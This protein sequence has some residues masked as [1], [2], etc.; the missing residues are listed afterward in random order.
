[1][2]QNTTT[3]PVLATHDLGKRFGA[4]WA[5]RGIQLTLQSGSITG[6]LGPNGAGK[7]TLIRLC[8]GLLRPDAG[9]VSVAGVAAPL[10][11]ELTVMHML[12]L[13]G[14]LYGLHGAHLRAA[15][16]RAVDEFCL[17][18][19]QHRRISVLSTGMRQR[20][21]IASAMLHQPELLLLDEPTVGLDPDV[22]R[23]IWDCLRA[24]AQ[25]GVAILFTTHYLEEAARLCQL[26]HLIVRGTV[27]MS[28]APADMDGSAERFEREYLRI[29]Q[30]ETGA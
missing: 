8:A 15:C 18:E 13:Q 11:G 24:V 22:R 21:A 14:V 26:V 29:V 17:G 30:Q 6:L 7:T 27:V 9:H 23:H 19:F 1:M 20:A 5:V 25:R 4:L 10:T 16:A 12:R 28:I 2:Q 3:T